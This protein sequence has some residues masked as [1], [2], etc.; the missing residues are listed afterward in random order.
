MYKK[1]SFEENKS[2]KKSKVE[3]FIS[4]AARKLRA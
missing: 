1:V 3:R 4:G 2:F